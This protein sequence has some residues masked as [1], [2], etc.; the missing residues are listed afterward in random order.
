MIRKVINFLFVLLTIGINAQQKYNAKGQEK[1]IIVVKLTKNQLNK[2]EREEQENLSSRN[3]I[4][5]SKKEGHAKFGIQD[6]D[7]CNKKVKA[8]SIKRVF[9]YAGKHEKKHRKHGLHLWYEIEFDKNIDINEAISLYKNNSEIEIA[10]ERN[11]TQRIE[12]N[13]NILKGKASNNK[14]NKR[15]TFPNDPRFHEQWHYHNTGQEDGIGGSDIKLKEAWELETGDDRVIV[16]IMDYGVDPTHPDL[17]GNMWVN[18]GEIPGNNI[19]DDNNGY[20]DDIYGYDFVA[21]T[22][23]IIV[24]NNH[25]TH[26]AGTIAAETNNGIGVS[27]IAGGTGNNDGV[28]IMTNII[29]GDG[30]G[31]IDDAFVYA[32][33]NGAVISQNSWNSGGR[34]EPSRKAAID[35]FIAEAGGANQAMNGGILFFS[36]GNNNL[37][38]PAYPGAYEKVFSVAA[39]DNKDKKSNFSNY[40]NWTNI[41]APGGESTIGKD[42]STILST[43]YNNRYGF[44]WGTSMATPHVSGVAALI[45]SYNYGNITPEQVKKALIQGVDPIDHLN[46]GYEGKLGVGRLNAVRSLRASKGLGIPDSVTVSNEGLNNV[47]LSWNQVSGATQYGIRYKT[48]ET[49]QWQETTLITSTNYTLEGLEK[50]TTYE[51]Q[52]WSKNSSETSYYSSSVIFSTTI[53]VILPPSSITLSNITGARAEVSWDKSL[54]AEEYDVDYKSIV[55]STWNTINVQEVDGRKGLLKNLMGATEYMVRIR[56]KKGTLISEYS[57]IVS[58]TTQAMD[59]NGNPFWVST[60]AYNGGDVVVYDGTIYKANWY[61]EAGKIPENNRAWSKQ[62]TC[63][64]GGGNISPTVVIT[65]PTNEQIIEQETLSSIILSANAVDSDG[66]IASVQ[67]SVNG[68]NLSQGNDIS[69]L[70][71]VFGSY[72]IKVE[73]TDDKGA[74]AKDEVTITVKEKVDNEVPQVNITSLSNGQVIEQETLFSIMLSA[75]ATDSDGTIAS[76][77]FSVNGTNLPQGNNIS[78]LPN[79]FGSYTIKVEVTDDKGAKATNEVIITVK[80]KIANEAPQVTITSLSDGQLVEQETLSSIVLS[81]NAVDSDGTIASVQFSVDGINLSQGNDISWLPSAFGSYTIKV[82]VIDNKGAKATDEITITVKQKVNNEVPQVTITSLSNGQVIEQETLSSITL[83]ANAT[84]SDGT[85]ASIQFSVDGTNLSSGNTISWLPA[86]FK[87]Y[88]IKV[89][90]IDDKGAKASDEINVTIKE[91]TT[92]GGCN[93]IQ[94]WDANTEYKVKG[95]Q[96][97]HKGNI[98]ES[99]WWTKNEEPGTGGPWGPWNLISSC[100]SFS[101]ILVYP[102]PAQ[103]IVNIT[104]DSSSFSKITLQEVSGSYKKVLENNNRQVKGKKQ[105]NYN[106]SGAPKGIYLLKI[107]SS[108]KVTTKKIIIN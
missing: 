108:N 97:A 63:I 22:G 1:G 88:T 61:S 21:N 29:H 99:K 82:E 19:D 7:F 4:L 64:Q 15:A 93:N 6:V 83:S 50:G 20:V 16:S 98:Y 11:K 70:P 47:K 31:A 32:A 80:E 45:V 72:T 39:T 58:F 95:I 10:H 75:D 34:F 25:G 89:E 44:S 27:G 42:K 52:V 26:I 3:I 54:G 14:I 74:K 77:Q 106:L 46:K 103:N 76:I 86:F 13:N 2:L 18:S 40:G 81:A 96:V 79:A 8:T 33:D 30:R 35:Y 57:S 100:S 5:S 38:S 37:T 90:V 62:G 105:L 73:V 60:K 36:A 67:F 53:D 23:T 17:D 104:I 28:R 68:T 78:W 51:V 69:W 56:G 92:G 85:I 102:N 41:A 66:T 48:L 87:R 107:I 55:A 65:S 49:S 91:K 43:V 71:S 9:R 84:D 94:I 59:C 24:N 101:E 12:T